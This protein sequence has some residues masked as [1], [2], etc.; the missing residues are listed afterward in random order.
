MIGRSRDTGRARRESKQRHGA[1]LQR[2][3]TEAC[4]GSHPVAHPLQQITKSPRFRVW[5]LLRGFGGPPGDQLPR[6]EGHEFLAAQAR[7]EPFTKLDGRLCPVARKEHLRQQR[8]SAQRTL[9]LRLSAQQ[10][11]VR[12]QLSRT[13]APHGVE[14]VCRGPVRGDIGNTTPP[15]LHAGCNARRGR[16]IDSSELTCAAPDSYPTAELFLVAQLEQSVK[17]LRTTRRLNGHVA[18]GVGLPP[19]ERP[20][21]WY[22]FAFPDKLPQCHLQ[23]HGEVPLVR[24]WYGTLVHRV[25]ARHQRHR[26]EQ[27]TSVPY[28]V[29]M[30][31]V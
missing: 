14:L 29:A 11:T 15:H 2:S 23:S 25:V 20:L 4:I 27:R 22:R 26:L 18:L 13:G 16:T 21:R 8:Q 5:E 31:A 10:P 9:A 6:V 1:C 24:G 17:L 7:V 30:T 19:R 3:T 28:P 12:V